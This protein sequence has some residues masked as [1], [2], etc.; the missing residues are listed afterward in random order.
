MAIVSCS[1]K[2]TSSYLLCQAASSSN[3]ADR[4]AAAGGGALSFVGFD[5]LAGDGGGVG[6]IT[7]S[8]ASDAFSISDSQAAVL[9][10]FFR[11]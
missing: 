6:Y 2:S 11:P 9:V 10:R 5:A 4:L 3:A 7:P 1:L 8:A